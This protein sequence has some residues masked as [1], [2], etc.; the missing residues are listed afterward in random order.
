[1][2]RSYL[3]KSSW[4]CLS[5]PVEIEYKEFAGYG[6]PSPLMASNM[7]LVSQQ[8]TSSTGVVP[9]STGTDLFL[10]CNQSLR[11]QKTMVWQ[12]CWMTELFVLSSNMA[13][14]L[15][16]FCISRNWLQTKNI[17]LQGFQFV[18]F[19]IQPRFDRRLPTAVLCRVFFGI[20]S[21]SLCSI[22]LTV[23][24]FWKRALLSNSSPKHSD[25]STLSK[26]SNP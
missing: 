7:N 26:A 21:L 4:K 23:V 5:N 1:M 6:L 12:P 24:G 9:K 8:F 17:H 20:L 16:S 15:L 14:M 2:F 22:S 11:I 13:A 25:M 18:C 3:F 19:G 10:V